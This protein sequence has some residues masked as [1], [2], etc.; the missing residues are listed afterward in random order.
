MLFTVWQV[1]RLS[2]HHS[3]PR[4]LISRMIPGSSSCIC[5]HLLPG[6]TAISLACGFADVTQSR[7]GCKWAIWGARSLHFSSCAF[8]DVQ[9]VMQFP[10]N[11]ILREV[12]IS[13][14]FLFDHE[15]IRWLRVNSLHA[16]ILSHALDYLAFSLVY[17]SSMS[18]MRGRNIWEKATSF[19][20]HRCHSRMCAR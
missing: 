2:P 6:S 13:R 5:M 9:C 3:S 11:C 8:T 19:I 17:H 12:L 10:T 7:S 20:H 1:E 14:Y 16:S 4:P 15:S 18:R